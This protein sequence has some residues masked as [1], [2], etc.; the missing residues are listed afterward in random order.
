MKPIIKSRKSLLPLDMFSAAAIISPLVEFVDIDYY[1][2][3]LQISIR[4]KEL[5]YEKR[6]F[7]NYRYY[8]DNIP[9]IQGAISLISE[10]F[11]KYINQSLVAKSL[12]VDPNMVF[13]HFLSLYTK[14]TSNPEPLWHD[15][16][17]L[18]VQ[19]LFMPFNPSYYV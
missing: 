7:N 10:E 1:G 3:H 14:E 4:P 19:T 17:P 15:A 11:L 5:C 9:E 6:G 2:G 8:P 16:D 13:Y 12:M 18:P